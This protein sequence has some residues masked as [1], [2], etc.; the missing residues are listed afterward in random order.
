MFL[1]GQE[2]LWE[3]ES[4]GS[5]W[6]AGTAALNFV[7]TG[8][9]WAFCSSSVDFQVIASPCRWV[10]I[11]PSSKRRRTYPVEKN[12][13]RQKGVATLYPGV[14]GLA[15]KN[16]SRGSRSD[17]VVDAYEVNFYT[18]AVYKVCIWWCLCRGKVFSHVVLALPWWA[19][20]SWVSPSGSFFSVENTV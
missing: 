12:G 1:G 13:E 11:N 15:G 3:S 16:T 2:P 19:F 17:S 14:L 6:E 4:M 18:V 5:V 9:S 20:D 8:G 7:A 10:I